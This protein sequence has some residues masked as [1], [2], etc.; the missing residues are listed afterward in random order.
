MKE[1]KP[2]LRTLYYVKKSN[3]SASPVKVGRCFT[4]TAVFPGNIAQYFAKAWLNDSVSF[5][6]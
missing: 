5:S 6:L 4:D 1:G 2:V 3:F